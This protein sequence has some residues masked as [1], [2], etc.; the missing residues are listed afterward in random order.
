MA[1]ERREGYLGGGDWTLEGEATEVASTLADLRGGGSAAAAIGAVVG[2]DALAAATGRF[3]HQ[4]FPNC[5][6][7]HLRLRHCRRHR[8]RF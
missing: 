1:E 2:V 5:R 4:G 8:S 7:F 3:C 6:Q